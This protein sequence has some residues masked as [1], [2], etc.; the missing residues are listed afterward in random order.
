MWQASRMTGQP[1]T[2]KPP[3]SAR[4][5]FSLAVLV[6]EV[7]VVLLAALVLVG[8]RL[9]PAGPIW[10]AAGSLMALCVVAAATL[11]HGVGYWIGWLVQILLLA[12]AV[13]VPTMLVLGLVYGALWVTAQRLGGRI[14]AERGERYREEIAHADRVGG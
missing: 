14:D 13:A 8:L 7:L 6:S 12:S 9:A 1:L 3:S 11:S 2:V 10:V 5:M 4:R